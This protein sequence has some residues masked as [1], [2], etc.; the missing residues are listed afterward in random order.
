M[1]AI[2]DTIGV[3]YADLR[4]PDPR[5][6]TLINGALGEAKT[7]LNVGAGTGPYEPGDRQVTAIDSSSEMIRQRRNSGARVVQSVAEALP[8]GDACFDAAMAVLTVHHWSDKAKGFRELRRVTRG[9]ITIL[10][11]DPSC[12]YYWLAEYLPEIVTLDDGKMP[13]MTAYEE[14]LGPVEITPVPVPHDCT[15]GFLAAYWRRP[16]AYLDPRIRAAI[17]SFWYIEDVDEKL[18]KLANDLESGAWARRNADLLDRES[19]DVGYR[20]VTTL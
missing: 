3:N 11:F 13:L 9:T 5:I 8:F 14:G 16:A 7:V 12:Q 2:Y 1:A 18:Q 6:E 20:L 19:V 15:D 17:S 10:T 4:K